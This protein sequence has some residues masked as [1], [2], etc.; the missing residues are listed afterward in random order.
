VLPRRHRC[1]TR[2]LFPPAVRIDDVHFSVAVDVAG[3][4]AVSRPWAW[5]GDI[6]G[7]PRAK[8]ICRIRVRP[9]HATAAAVDDVELAVTVNVFVRGDFSAA[10]HGGRNPIP[11]AVF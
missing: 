1:A 4:G 2:G 3:T 6:D 9:G 8:R 10:H 7:D 11:T 5:T